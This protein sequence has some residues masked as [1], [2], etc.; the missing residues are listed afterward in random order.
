MT[1]AAGG[2]EEQWSANARAA[3]RN[4]IALAKAAEPAVTPE[5]RDIVEA[6]GGTLTRLDTRFKSEESLTDKILRKR[7]PSD[8]AES[9]VET[10]EDVLRYTAV[11][12]D[13]DH[14][15]AGTLICEALTNA[16]YRHIL[17][18]LGW[19]TVGYKG[20]NERFESPNGYRFEL[21]IHTA[22]S[23]HKCKVTHP[24]YRELRRP[25]TPHERKWELRQLR[26]HEFAQVPIPPGTPVL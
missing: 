1:A 20:R 8:D 16:G 3:A 22:V 17:Q 6:H 19:Q 25:D 15:A 9:V 11:L 18:C 23:L 4:A 7:K 13:E 5:V 12:P 24:L 21:Q 26:D 2:G 10:I 14:W